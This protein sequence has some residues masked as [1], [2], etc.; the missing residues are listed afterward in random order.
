[1]IINTYAPLSVKA[2]KKQNLRE[3]YPK[4]FKAD[5]DWQNNACLNY[6]SDMS[7]N[8]IE[9]Y[10]VAGDQLVKYVKEGSCEQDFLVY[11]IA[12]LYRHHIELLLKEIIKKG[13]LLYDKND[14]EAQG[15]HKLS[16]LWKRSVEIINSV[17]DGSID[18]KDN[19]KLI[20]YFI[21]EFNQIDNLSFS[22][23][24][25]LDKKGQRL[26][27]GIKYINLRHLSDCI[28]SMSEFIEAFL[29]AIEVELEPDQDG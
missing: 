22:F 25:P 13:N 17:T 3:K 29:I 2:M 11:P 28:N 14:T 8:Y 16:P 24:Y 12:F 21:D 10:K 20:K 19:I 27:E 26:L 1:M 5:D 7:R 18:T 6:S 23:R 4:L 9:G 15:S